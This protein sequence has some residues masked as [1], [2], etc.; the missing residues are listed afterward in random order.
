MDTAEKSRSHPQKID[1]LLVFRMLEKRWELR[2]DQIE[3]EKWGI[4]LDFLLFPTSLGCHGGR[5]R[6]G[7]QAGTWGRGKGEPGCDK[8]VQL[9]MDGFRRTWTLK[10]RSIENH[11]SLGNI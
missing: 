6:K 2:Q 10:I 11:K 3:D 7:G 8:W 5:R 1:F 9:D 4:C